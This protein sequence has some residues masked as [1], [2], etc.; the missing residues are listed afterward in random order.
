MLSLQVLTN[1]GRVGEPEITV[2]DRW[3][4]AKR[5]QLPPAFRRCEWD[6]AD[7]LVRDVLFKRGDDHFAR[8]C[9]ERNTMN[10]EHDGSFTLGAAT[11]VLD[12]A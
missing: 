11:L 8:M 12:V 3:N 9:G 10:L 7:H 4:N 6:D 2:F 1:D 5:A